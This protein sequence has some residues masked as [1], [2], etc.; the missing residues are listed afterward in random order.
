[1]SGDDYLAE[2][3]RAGSIDLSRGISGWL[4]RMLDRK[5]TACGQRDR[6][7]LFMPRVFELAGIS[8]NDPTTVLEIGCGSG[9]AIS[10]IHPFVR[11][12]A[13]DRG[14]L[15]RD[16]LEAQGV[17]FHEIDVA[18]QPM[19][20]N[21]GQ[22]DL[23]VLNHLIEHI[24]DCEFFV[25]QLR[26]VLRP[27]GVVYVRTPNLERVKW[28]FWDDYT[29]VKPFTPRALDHLMRT[30]GFERRFML[31]S[32]HPRIFLDTLTKG[33]LRTV[34]FSTLLGGKE[35]EAGYVLVTKE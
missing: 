32:D 14:S 10:Y 24:A 21:D 28:C 13:V 23:I 15:Y 27:G 3:G 11:Y 29:H 22:V 6:H 33:F 26:R 7:A 18:I 12:I 20:I 2:Y 25:R 8:L 34:L 30:V 5:A 16:Q 4:R 1:M 31:D 19:P 9:W 35:I 17:E